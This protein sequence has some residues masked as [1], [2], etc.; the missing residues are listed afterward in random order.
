MKIREEHGHITMFL[1]RADIKLRKKIDKYARREVKF[2]PSAK[3]VTT[4]KLYRDKNSHIRGRYK[5]WTK[6][7]FFVTLSTMMI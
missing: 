7:S 3:F 4:Y 1:A 6:F 2:V 5:N